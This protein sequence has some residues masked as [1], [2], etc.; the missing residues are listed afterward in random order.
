MSADLID[1]HEYFVY[2]EDLRLKFPNLKTEDVEWLTDTKKSLPIN[3]IIG[4]NKYNNLI[5][6]QSKYNNYNFSNPSKPPLFITIDELYKIKIYESKNLVNPKSV[7]NY[8]EYVRN[9]WNSKSMSVDTIPGKEINKQNIYNCFV[10]YFKIVEGKDFIKNTDSVSNLEI[11][12]KY[13]I[14]DDSFFQHKLLSKESVSS[15][16][17]GIL[18]LGSYGN[19]KTSYMKVFSVMFEEISKYAYSEKWNNYKQWQRLRFKSI[20]TERLVIEF[21]SMLDMDSKEQKSAKSSFFYKYSGFNYCFGDLTK[22]KESS[23]FGK[24]DLMRLILKQRY[25]NLSIK[26]KEDVIVGFRKTYIT[27]NIV[28]TIPESLKLIQEKYGNDIY[29]RF[30]EMFNIIEFKGKS[31][32]K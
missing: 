7:S 23:N 31:L 30:F 5:D 27:M 22:E 14:K 18:I 25:D 9:L 2:K 21:D 12:I 1:T 13:F 10:Y 3:D 26:N 15:F 20:E 11:L 16:N 19:G 4:I 8:N 29:D 32:R 17:K 24:R 6:K 28:N